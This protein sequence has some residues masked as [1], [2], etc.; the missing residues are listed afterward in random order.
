MPDIDEKRARFKRLAAQ[1]TNAVV[2]ALRILG[3]CGNRS[4]YEYTDEEVRK[5]FDEV[6]HSVKET[7]ERFQSQRERKFR[8]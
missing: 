1:R 5:V 4:T 6:E 8:L 2:K 3:N 7:K